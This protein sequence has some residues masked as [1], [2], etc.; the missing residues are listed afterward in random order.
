MKSMKYL[1][2]MGGN[3]LMDLM[4]TGYATSPLFFLLC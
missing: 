3:D 1:V 2:E 4:K